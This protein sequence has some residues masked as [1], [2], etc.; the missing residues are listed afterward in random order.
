MEIGRISAFLLSAIS[1]QFNFRLQMTI[2][3]HKIFEPH[4][5]WPCGRGEVEVMEMG[6]I[7]AIY[8]F[9]FRQFQTV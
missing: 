8:F 2:S 5:S 6:R 7:L 4:L 1:Y 9:Y 3:I